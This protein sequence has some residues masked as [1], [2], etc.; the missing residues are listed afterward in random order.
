MVSRGSAKLAQVLCFGHDGQTVAAF[1]RGYSSLQDTVASQHSV[2]SESAAIRSVST[3]EPRLWTVDRGAWGGLQR[4]NNIVGAA[5]E[6][7]AGDEAQ[8]FFAPP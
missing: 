1:Q 3:L 6:S 8:V 4:G 5:D 7:G 2:I